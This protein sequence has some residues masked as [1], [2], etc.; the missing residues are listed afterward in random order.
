MFGVPGQHR[1]DS[2][3]LSKIFDP[4]DADTNYECKTMHLG[5]E[6]L[7]IDLVSLFYWTEL[8]TSYLD[9]RRDTVLEILNTSSEYHDS[10]VP[11]TRYW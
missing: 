6:T 8:H 5:H 11:C 10:M 4:T 7:N 9:I 2:L 3:P 1:M